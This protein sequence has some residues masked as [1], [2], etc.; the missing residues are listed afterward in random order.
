[1]IEG[2][3]KGASNTKLDLPPRKAIGKELAGGMSDTP[4]GMILEYMGTAARIPGRLL[5]A[6]D[7]FMKGILFQVELERFQLEN[8]MRL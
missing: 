5:V 4:L 8:T 2:F 6:E 3:K 1:M 7:E